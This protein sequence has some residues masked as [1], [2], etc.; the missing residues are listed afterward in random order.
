MIICRPDISFAITKLSQFN[1]NPCRIH[2]EALRQLL[3]YLCTTNH[4][5]I[6]F[7]RQTPHPHLPHKPSPHISKDPYERKTQIMTKPYQTIGITDSDW[8]A[9][10][11]HR[12]SVSGFGCLF[13]GGP[14]VY[15]TK[16]QKA[17]ALSSTEAEFYALCELGKVILYIRSVLH[18][19][20]IEQH[21][22]TSIYE[23]NRGCMLIVKSGHP[24]RRVRHVDIKQLAVL[25]WVSQDL[26]DIRHIQSTDNPADTLTKPLGKIL[27]QRHNDVLMGK[28]QPLYASSRNHEASMICII[29][30]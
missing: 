7:W 17:I 4:E 9:D 25:E 16:Y 29:D 13:A 23:D 1:T 24:T 20:G 2:F 11:Q 26:L 8:A 21:Q 30:T 6:Y 12:H 19:L 28:I 3:F 18:D 5:G 10:T 27:Y 14:V 15:K 22:A